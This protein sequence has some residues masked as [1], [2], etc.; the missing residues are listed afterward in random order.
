MASTHPQLGTISFTD[1]NATWFGIQSATLYGLRDTVY[2][3]PELLI[4][5]VQ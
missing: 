3:Q 1:E 4:L 5:A 2:G